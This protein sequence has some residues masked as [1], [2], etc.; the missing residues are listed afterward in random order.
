[1]VK[2]IVVSLE[3]YTPPKI[4]ILLLQ[5][6]YRNTVVRKKF[7]PQIQIVIKS[8]MNVNRRLLMVEKAVPVANVKKNINIQ[9]KM[10]KSNVVPMV[11]YTQMKVEYH[12]AVQKNRK[13]VELRVVQQGKNVMKKVVYVK[14]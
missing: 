6:Q 1:M 7:V 10:M 14:L 3:N 4:Q 13:C 2:L 11:K 8:S 9:M 12:D 5:K